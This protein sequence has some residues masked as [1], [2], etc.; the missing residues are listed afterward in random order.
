MLESDGMPTLKIKNVALKNLESV[1]YTMMRVNH[2]RYLDIVFPHNIYTS[3]GVEKPRLL[4]N[5]DPAK[6]KPAMSSVLEEG[7]VAAISK[8]K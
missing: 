8:I 6:F 3:I 4:L 2:L 5:V 1:N 7:I